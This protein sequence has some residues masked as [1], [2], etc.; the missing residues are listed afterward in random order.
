MEET[1]EQDGITLASLT[2]DQQGAFDASRAQCITEVGDALQAEPPSREEVVAMYDHM[3]ATASCLTDLG[4]LV[5]SPVSEA[6]W[7]DDYLAGRPP[8]SPYLD[9]PDDLPAAE[10]Q[11]V[12]AQCPQTLQN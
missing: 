12:N 11:R 6:A 1:P 8:W 4:Y 9:L 3:V 5:S 10:W 7:V 2:P